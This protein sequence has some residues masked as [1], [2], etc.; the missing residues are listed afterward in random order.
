M[1]IF[2]MPHLAYL[3]GVITMI[4]IIIKIIINAGVNWMQDKNQ[5]FHKGLYIP[6]TFVQEYC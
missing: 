1:G 2:P 3:K 4:I 5:S 6:K